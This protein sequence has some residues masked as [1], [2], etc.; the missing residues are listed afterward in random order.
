MATIFILNGPNLNLLGQREPHIYGHETLDDVEAMCIDHGRA[1]DLEVDFRQSNHEGVLV[2]WVHEA[3][4]LADGLVCNFG[5]LTHT[6]IALRDALSATALPTVEVHLTNTF[7]RE[8]FRHQ[9]HTAAV[10]TGAIMGLGPTGYR[11]ALSALVDIIDAVD[12]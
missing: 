2:D 11:L 6:S 7:A 9:S 12:V 1:L 3:K 10:S 5:A 8:S 4:R